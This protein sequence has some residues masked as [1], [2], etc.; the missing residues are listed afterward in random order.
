MTKTLLTGLTASALSCAFISAATINID[1]YTY[2]VAPDNLYPDSSGNELTD[3]VDLTGSWGSPDPFSAAPLVG[4]L[5]TN[6]DLTLNFAST[7]AIDSVEIWLADSDGV[8]GVGLPSEITLSTSGGFSQSYSVTN[9][10]GNGS[11]IPVTISDLNLNTDNLRIQATRVNQWTMIS[12]VSVASVPEPSSTALLGL[13]G[14]S[15][16]LRRRR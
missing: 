7:V 11:T 8:S 6:P 16:I 9:P 4:W 1:S 15:L 10:A 13:G 5:N 14:L 2:N 12:E 3:G